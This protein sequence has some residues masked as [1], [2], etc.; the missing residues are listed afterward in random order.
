MCSPEVT[1]TSLHP[2]RLCRLAVFSIKPTIL[3]CALPG[4]RSLFSILYSLQKYSRS[5][6][7]TSKKMSVNQVMERSHHLHLH[8]SLLCHP[9]LSSACA[10][11]FEV[12]VTSVSL[13]PFMSR[14]GLFNTNQRLSLQSSF[15]CCFLKQIVL[16]VESK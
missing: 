7:K 5:S 10:C 13:P 16:L 2:P 8:H 15:C 9:S 12:T 11:R 3:S 6:R 14:R 1:V 4:C